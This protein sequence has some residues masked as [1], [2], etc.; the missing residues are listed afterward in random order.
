MDI[1]STLRGSAKTKIPKTLD[2]YG[3]GWVGPGLSEKKIGKSSQNS[4]KQVRI[5]YSVCIHC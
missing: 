3:S 2:Y 4:P 5:L 1:Q